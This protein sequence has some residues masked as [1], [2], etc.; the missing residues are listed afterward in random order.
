MHAAIPITAPLLP[1]LDPLLDGYPLSGR[2]RE[3]IAL[4]VLGLENKEIAARIGCTRATIDCYWLRIRRKTGTRS[5]QALLARLLLESLHEDGARPL[6]KIF[7][8]RQLPGEGVQ[9][10]LS[11]RESTGDGHRARVR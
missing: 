3:V 5:R 2:E 10:S 7:G 11:G 1:K 8:T 4:A 9:P 6:V